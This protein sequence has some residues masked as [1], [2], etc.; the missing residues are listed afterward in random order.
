VLTGIAVMMVAGV[1]KCA[2]DASATKIA[3]A[4]SFGSMRFA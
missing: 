3:V 4:I 1:M 2:V